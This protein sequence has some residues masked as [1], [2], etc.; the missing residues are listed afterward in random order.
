MAEHLGCDLETA[1]LRVFS[2]RRRGVRIEREPADRYRAV[3]DGGRARRPVRAAQVLRIRRE[4][5]GRRRMPALMQRASPASAHVPEPRLGR[6]RRHRHRPVRRVARRREPRDHA[7]RGV[8]RPGL[9]WATTPE[10]EGKVRTLERAG[11]ARDAY[12]LLN[13]KWYEAQL[14]S[15]LRRR[16]QPRGPLG[17]TL[18]WSATAA[19]AVPGSG[20]TTKYH[21]DLRARRGDASTASPSCQSGR[22]GWHGAAPAGSA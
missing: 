10:R 3:G 7:A 4:R 2:Q 15:G 16:P 9:T 21:D 22:G 5:A 18:G 14:T 17:T 8:R 20:S 11:R 6:A 13:P 1:A 19:E 12:A